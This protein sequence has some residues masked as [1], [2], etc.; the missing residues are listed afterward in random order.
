M[1]GCTCVLVQGFPFHF[2]KEVI[3]LNGTYRCRRTTAWISKCS[4]RAMLLRSCT[5]I[6]MR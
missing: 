2:H 1:G 4:A 3:N 5:S 6:P